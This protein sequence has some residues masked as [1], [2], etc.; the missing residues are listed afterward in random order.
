MMILLLHFVQYE[1]NHISESCFGTDHY[2]G[3]FM[4]QQ[5]IHNLITLNYTA[6]EN[7]LLQKASIYYKKNTNILR[8]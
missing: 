6:V 2:K 4:Y 7:L 5:K 8:Y 1:N 3:L